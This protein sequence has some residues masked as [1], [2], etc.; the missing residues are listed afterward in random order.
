VA[1]F[2]HAKPWWFYLQDCLMGTLPWSVLLPGLLWSCRGRTH[3]N[4]LRLPPAIGFALLSLAWTFFFFSAAGSKRSGYI[5]PAMPLMAF[6]LGGYL[7]SSLNPL[8]RRPVRELST[9]GKLPIV[10]SIM[11]LLGGVVGFFVACEQ[12]LVKSH[13]A[14]VVGGVGLAAILV[15]VLLGRRIRAAQGWKICGLSTFAVLLAAVQLALPSYARRFSMREQVSQLRMAASDPELAVLCFPRCW[16]SVTFYLRR[17]DIVTF[18]MGQRNEL[19]AFLDKHPRSLAFIKANRA[20]DKFRQHLPAWLE[21]V[22]Q[23]R[24]GNVVAGWIRPRFEV[25]VEFPR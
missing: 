14:Y 12:S 5:L 11:A 6:S 7:D 21:F 15:I 4:G 17:T 24:Q 10:L 2:D 13:T 18:R 22:P 8:R 16:D 9:M 19:A 3:D 20:L 23:G 1:P 25:A